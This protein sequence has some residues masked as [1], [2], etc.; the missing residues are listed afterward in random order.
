M[1]ASSRRGNQVLP[2]CH[3]IDHDDGIGVRTDVSLSPGDGKIH[4]VIPFAVMAMFSI[5]SLWERT[6]V[7]PCHLVR[8]PTRGSPF[9]PR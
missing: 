7:L 8:I 2:Q 4:G 1:D 9:L 5:I 3:G 6:F